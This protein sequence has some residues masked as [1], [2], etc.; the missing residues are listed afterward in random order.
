MALTKT[1][2]RL[3]L[4]GAMVTP[5]AVTSAL[6]YDVLE[7][8]AV[9]SEL[10]SKSPLYVVAKFGERYF[11]GGEH[12]HII[13]S[14]DGGNTWTQA[15]VPVRSTIT[16]IFF[17]ND[18]LGWAV[19][20][21]GVILHSSD[22]GK[23]W[24]KQYD[25]NR[26]GEEGLAY[27]TKM[28]EEDPDNE[29]FP[30][31]IEEMEFAISQ[32]ADKPFFRV[33]FV[34]E[35]QGYAVGAYGMFMV[36]FDGGEHWQHRLDHAENDSFNHVFDFS[37]LPE[38][39]RFFIAGEAGLFLIGDVGMGYSSRVWSI[40]WEGS[41]F[42][43]VDSADG[44]IILGGLR[45]RMFRTADEGETWTVVEKPPSSSIV[46]SIRL[47]DGRL[48]AGGVAGEVLVSTDG[49]MSFAMS[50]ASGKAPAIYDMAEG[51]GGELL[52]AGP[53][54]ITHVKLDQ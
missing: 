16:D 32:G 45:G 5:A 43:S 1:L 23:T 30:L 36:T 9:P 4:L 14:N 42:T 20:H 47:A 53:R 39:G 52:L 22:G 8:P 40:P 35:K 34:N 13:F 2:L 38:P 46:T 33:A 24:V 50:P 10:A 49:G 31:L 28:A 18:Q 44:A 11:A 37:P 26:Y 51:E 12:G 41:F 29:L 17:I 21:E 25:G 19:G 48:V 27:Y 7:L 3:V 6:E 15:E 54:G